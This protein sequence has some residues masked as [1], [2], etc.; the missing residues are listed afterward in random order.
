MTREELAI[1]QGPPGTGKTFTSV[2]ALQ[3]LVQTLK[4]VPV[5]VAAET[6]HALDQL[7][8]ACSQAF[9]AKYVRLGGRSEDEEISSNTMFQMTKNSV[10][11]KSNPRAEILRKRAEKDIE[12]CISLCFPLDTVV[13]AQTFLDAELLT[14]DQYSSLLDILEGDMPEGLDPIELWLEHK[15]ENDTTVAPPIEPTDVDIQLDAE[16]I[17]Q[18]EIE[19]ERNRLKGLFVPI[20]F[21]EP[22]SGGSKNINTCSTLQR[23]GSWLAQNADLYNI[24]APRRGLVYRYLRQALIGKMTAKFRALIRNYKAQCDAIYATRWAV[25]VEVIH[26]AEVQ[27]I[28]CTTTG[29]TKYRGMIAALKPKVLLIEEAAEAREANITSALY[30]SLDQLILVGDHQQL[31]PS[32]DVQELGFEPYNFHVSLFERLVKAGVSYSKLSVQR[33]MI[34]AIRE[35]VQEFYPHITDHEIVRDPAK[36]PAVPGMNGINHWWFDHSFPDYQ[37]STMSRANLGEAQMIAG[38]AKYLVQNGMLPS[39][40]TVLTYYKS[41]VEMIE[42]EIKRVFQGSDRETLCSVRTVDGFQGEQNDVI[43]LSQVRS[44]GESPEAS[45]GFVQNENRAVVA[46]SRAKCGL[47]V[48]GNQAILSRSII[49]VET[50][51][52]VLKVF[53]KKR[54]GE[55]E[56]RIGDYLPVTCASHGKMTKISSADDWEKVPRGG[57]RQHCQGKCSNGHPCSFK[58]HLIG[59]PACQ[60]RRP[61]EKKLQCGHACS[62]LCGEPCKCS[63]K[64]CSRPSIRSSSEIGAPKLTIKAPKRQAKSVASSR[65]S[66]SSG[67]QPYNPYQTSDT[68]L[69]DGYRSHMSL[70]AQS[71]ASGLDSDG[72]SVS[73]RSAQ[74]SPSSTPRAFRETYIPTFVEDGNRIV[75]NFVCHVGG[76]EAL[77]EFSEDETDDKSEDKGEKPQGKGKTD[78]HRS[79]VLPVGEALAIRGRQPGSSD[80]LN[81]L[82]S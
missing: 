60:C 47:Y 11:N 23:A 40:I 81:D 34:P 76:E 43:L 6:N 72:W 19:D 78:V 22:R 14:E 68:L 64:A 65:A 29:L 71:G 18:D 80:I 62:S 12:N 31:V 74:T 21:R 26:E 52:K 46:L 1:V 61:C 41:Q 58:C 79:E 53:K 38:F 70:M 17:A 9:E 59:H 33:R 4:P 82:L 57:C 25:N 67:R 32:V 48:F 49:S 44:C 13:S 16:A 63:L 69:R 10:K 24:K 54:M 20:E 75:G 55:M 28:G 42:R 35:V 45:P 73:A 8:S 51:D 15:V 2:G 50:W 30:P 3:S 77:I 66:S 56:Q 27:I 39:Q 7:L 36:R 37:T 5:I